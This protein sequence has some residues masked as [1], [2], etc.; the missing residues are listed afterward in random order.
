ML[1]N[2]DGLVAG[3]SS[4]ATGEHRGFIADDSNITN[5]GTLGANGSSVAGLDNQGWVYSAAA[6]ASGGVLPLCMAVRHH[7][8]AERCGRRGRPR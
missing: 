1:V 6:T 2:A 5:L 7:D 3:T 8:G 4:T